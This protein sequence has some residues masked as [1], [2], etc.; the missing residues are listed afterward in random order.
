MRLNDGARVP[1][2]AAMLGVVDEGDGMG[3]RRG[4]LGATAGAVAV[5]ILLGLAACGGS[6]DE[7]TEGTN[8]ETAATGDSTESNGD[9]E[10]S[11]DP[12]SPDAAVDDYPVSPMSDFF[13]YDDMDT[14]EQ[15]QRYRQEEM[16]RQQVIAECMRAEGFEYTV[17][18]SKQ[19]FSFESPYQ[20]MTRREFVEKYGFGIST[21]YEEGFTPPEPNMEDQEVDP[22]NE[23]VDSLSSA[24]QT[25]YY[26][27]LYGP[28]QDEPS[29][30]ETVGT[31]REPV[32]DNFEYVPQGCEGKAYSDESSPEDQEF[33]EDISTKMSTE[34]YER[35]QADSRVV[36][37]TKAYAEC[38]SDAGYPE[39]TKQE[40]TWNEV[41]TRMEPIYDSMGGGFV[42]EEAASSDGV[43]A[44]VVAG[45]APVGGDGEP[46]YDTELLEQ[47]QAYELALAAADL[48]C[49][50]DLQRAMFE[51]SSEYEEQF[52]A[53]HGDELARYKELTNP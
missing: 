28:P 20:D 33:I 21:M 3:N 47:V 11:D 31:D 26:E 2:K 14:D 10:F 5:A 18:V 45:P 13:G 42:S 15:E 9:Q 6:G 43:S 51:V 24:E 27:A 41:S 53:E 36:D 34:I 22:N 32:E 39:I 4:R 38:M 50:A 25:A 17:F 29:P 12:F 19:S 46:T 30:E 8:D 44:T 40:D 1:M 49:G 48:E 23:Y 7:A 16:D 35:V 37:A 52:I